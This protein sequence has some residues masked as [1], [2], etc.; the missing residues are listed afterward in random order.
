M[1]ANLNFYQDTNCD[2]WPLVYPWIEE[3]C[4]HGDGWWTVEKLIPMLCKGE[5][6]LWVLEDNHEPQAA[7]ITAIADWDGT[8]VAECIAQGG[9]GVNAA[10]GEHLNTIEDWAREH[11]ATELYMRGRRGLS[12]VYRPYGYEEIAVT[13]RKAL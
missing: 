11:N 13:M 7:I 10:L 3:A 6:V 5:A 1:K 8:R 4:E 12:R 2:Q 9:S